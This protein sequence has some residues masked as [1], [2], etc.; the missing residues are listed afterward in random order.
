MNAASTIQG[1][2]I[3][4]KIKLNA[5]APYLIANKGALVSGGAFQFDADGNAFTKNYSLT[6][7]ICGI[8]IDGSPIYRKTVSISLAVDQDNYTI[9]TPVQTLFPG[10]TKVIN[11]ENRFDYAPGYGGIDIGRI[12]HQGSELHIIGGSFGG[13][14]T[15]DHQITLDYLKS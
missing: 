15:C 7:F 3:F 4:N 1:S 10:L 13:G 9:P 5:L 6:E 14:G 12:L 8:W 11:S 2:A